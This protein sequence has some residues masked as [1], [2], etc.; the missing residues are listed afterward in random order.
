MSLVN[1]L[2]KVAII[3]NYTTDKPW[4]TWMID[5]IKANIRRTFPDA[6]IGVYNAEAGDTLPDESTLDLIILTGGT[7][8]LL[9]SK[10]A[11]W[12]VGIMNLVK[13]VAEADSGPYLIG[14]CWGH[15]VINVALGGN[16]SVLKHGA[17]VRTPVS[18]LNRNKVC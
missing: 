9:E 1:R 3:Q 11:P 10:L 16:I 4:G 17:M 14:L 7:Y 15:Q 13:R 2:F 18:F 12:V 8:N 6:D 5:S